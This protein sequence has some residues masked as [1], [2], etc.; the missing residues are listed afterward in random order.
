MTL[1]TGLLLVA[2][3]LFAGFAGGLF[4]IGGGLIIVPVL[5][6][7]LVS[8]GLPEAAAIK[9][10]VATSMATIIVTSIRSVMRH[11]RHGNVDFALLKSWA[12]FM[13]AGAVLGAFLARVLDGQV[14][15]GVFGAGLI[16]IAIQRYL[17]SKEQERPAR[18]PL[19][20]IVQHGIAGLLGTVSSLLGIGG[21]VI[22]VLVL[23]RAGERVHRAVG[24]A[25]GFGLIIA[26]PGTLTY[27]LPVEAVPETIPLK[28]GY[29][30]VA[31]F[32]T[33]SLGTYLAAPLGASLAAR[34]SATLLTRIFSA[35]AIVTGVLL[36][37]EALLA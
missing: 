24:T 31:G 10:A 25:A 20:M 21:G 29:I 5:Y 12:P 34:L 15:T 19:P 33:I 3:G 2:T 37:R 26:I 1:L 30:S 14:L 22:G 6:L 11:H 4:G 35:Y 18:L 16:I 13:A 8:Q 9:T 7:I 23:T 32:L 17:N 28:V 27:L 36:V